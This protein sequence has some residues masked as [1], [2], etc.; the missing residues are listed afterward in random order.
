MGTKCFLINISAC[1]IKLKPW[2]CFS[3]I[4]WQ[5]CM[6][7]NYHLGYFYRNLLQKLESTLITCRSSLIHCFCLSLV[8]PLKRPTSKVSSIQTDHLPASYFD[9]SLFFFY[10]LHQL[11]AS[12]YQI[13]P[14]L[15]YGKN[16]Y[17]SQI[18]LRTIF[19]KNPKPAPAGR[20][21]PPTPQK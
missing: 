14:P 1:F 3:W 11:Q 5:I 19:F 6:K 4:F 18:F 12:D 15:T 10:F 16:I 17:T 13:F 7:C 2:E 9:C 8:S 21:V 20:I